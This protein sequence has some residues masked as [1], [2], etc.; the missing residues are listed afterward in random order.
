MN[1]QNERETKKNRLYLMQKKEMKES[2]ELWK[3][4]NS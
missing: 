3:E 2:L 4:L 1:V